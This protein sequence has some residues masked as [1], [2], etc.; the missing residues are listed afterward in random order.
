LDRAGEVAKTSLTALQR[1]HALELQR[2]RHEADAAHAARE[3]SW[4]AALE[5]AHAA[6]AVAAAA[7]QAQ[8][9]AGPLLERV[10]AL[11]TGAC[12]CS[13]SPVA[14]FSSEMSCL[15]ARRPLGVDLL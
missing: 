10:A 15:W 7:G 13:C 5:Q 14:I 1:Q 8:Q 3:S 6:A 12:M 4:A 11:E 9:A 2:V